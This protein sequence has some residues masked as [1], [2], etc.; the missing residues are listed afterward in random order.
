[1]FSTDKTLKK[2]YCVEENKNSS[3]KKS[4]KV[5]DPTSDRGK[6]QG[7]YTYKFSKK[8]R[9]SVIIFIYLLF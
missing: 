8:A 4:H 3:E 6:A 7:T 1:M 9:K 5:I 2:I